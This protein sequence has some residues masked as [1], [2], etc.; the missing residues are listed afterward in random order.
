M[1]KLI[2]GNLVCVN[3]VIYNFYIEGVLGVFIFDKDNVCLY[4]LC[5]FLYIMDLLVYILEYNV[6]VNN[7][8][9]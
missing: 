8:L 9:V 5:I 7:R 2:Y 1:L 3:L 6:I 4:V